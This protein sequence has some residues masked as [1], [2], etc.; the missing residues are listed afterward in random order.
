MLIFSTRHP[1]AQQWNR[2]TTLKDGGSCKRVKGVRRTNLAQ[3]ALKLVLP[4]AVKRANEISQSC[5]AKALSSEPELSSDE[6]KE[7]TKSLCD[8]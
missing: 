2:T 3:F 5:F 7:S 6:K 1:P 4:Y 8:A